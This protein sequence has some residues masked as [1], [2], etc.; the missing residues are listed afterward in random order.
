MHKQDMA[1]SEITLYSDSEKTFVFCI[2]DDNITL[3]SNGNRVFTLNDD[4][5]H[6]FLAQLRIYTKDTRTLDTLLKEYFGAENCIN[7]LVQ[8]ANAVG[9]NV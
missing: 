1:A 3:T 9:I 6:R 7:R 4:D 5:S 8:F 2:K